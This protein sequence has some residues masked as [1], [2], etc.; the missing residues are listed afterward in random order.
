MLDSNRKDSSK[1]TSTSSR[2]FDLEI[3]IDIGNGTT[4]VIKFDSNSNVG[5]L[6]SALEF[7]REYGVDEGVAPLIAESIVN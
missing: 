4:G 1:N 2:K 3:C 7:C 6:E 5:A